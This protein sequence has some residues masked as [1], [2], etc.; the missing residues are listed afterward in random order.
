MLDYSGLRDTIVLGLAMYLRDR[1]DDNIAVVLQEHGDPKPEYPFMTYSPLAPMDIPSPHTG[2]RSYTMEEV[3][4]E[5]EFW[6]HHDYQLNCSFTF[7]AYSDAYEEAQTM[8]LIASEWFQRAGK[9]WLKERG[10]VVR[11]IEDFSRRDSLVVVEYERRVG[12]D[13]LFRVGVTVSHKLNEYS[14]GDWIET[15]DVKRSE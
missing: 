2:L 1:Y 8:A 6:I 4:G 13:V 9:W 12:F 5:L 14:E 7:D 3:D 10:V 11:G 15:A